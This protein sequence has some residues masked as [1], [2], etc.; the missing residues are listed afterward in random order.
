VDAI[1]ASPL[2]VLIFSSHSNASPHV[3]R[4]IHNACAEDSAER[5]IPLR[6]EDVPHSKALRYYLG[7]A[8]WLDAT[9]PPLEG[10][11]R[12]LVEHVST[13]LPRK[14]EQP[15]PAAMP[16][17][18]RPPAP[19]VEDGVSL[20]RV[21]R[22]V[23]KPLLTMWLAAGAGALLL[24][25][26]V[27]AVTA[28]WLNGDPGGAN[29]NDGNANNAN[30]AN[31]NQVANNN[32]RFPP[33]LTPTPAANAN[34]SNPVVN[35]NGSVPATLTPQAQASPSASPILKPIPPGLMSSL[36]KRN[37][38]NAFSEVPGLSEVTVEVEGTEVTLGGVVY[39]Q[40]CRREAVILSRQWGGVT[41]VN[42]R[43]ATGRSMLPA[44]LICTK[45]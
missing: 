10:H 27:V 38:L 12:R 35:T 18:D 36:I 9:V 16:V 5:I 30:S 31:L 19:D 25:V 6:I 24:L 42:D 11:L 45:R 20:L 14:G 2:I 34:A 4:E 32:G 43:M 13:R 8:Q 29:S 40:D 26:A 22:K 17:P 1:S 37:V 44:K 21:D 15:S 28:Y 33:P 23:S 7:S 41:A 3:E 39:S